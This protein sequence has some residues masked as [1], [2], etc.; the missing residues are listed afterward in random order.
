VVHTSNE[1]RDV[2]R[3][4]QRQPRTFAALARD[5]SSSPE[6]SHGGLMGRFSRGQLPAELETA[7]FGLRPGE[8]SSPVQTPLGYHVL[9]LDAREPA[10][11]PALEECRE[12]L[13]AQLSRQNADRRIRA[14]VAGLLAR[15]KVNHEAVQA[16]PTS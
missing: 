6:A 10:H 4:L 16:R 2:R 14:Y 5:L 12:R 11:E 1:A 9:R 13:R 8:V 7:A 15:A 3:R